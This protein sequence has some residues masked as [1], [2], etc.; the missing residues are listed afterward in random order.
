[1]ASAPL[2]DAAP[3]LGRGADIGI[4]EKVHRRTVVPLA[5]LCGMNSKKNFFV[6]ID[7]LGNSLLCIRINFFKIC[8]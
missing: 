4:S 6:F 7:L 5:K 2:T 1:M 8:L 3:L